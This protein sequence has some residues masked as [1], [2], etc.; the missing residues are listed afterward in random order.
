VY[1]DHAAVLDR[2]TGELDGVLDRHA[3]VEQT[4]AQA[5]REGV[6]HR[7]HP[8]AEHP[9]DE[10]AEEH[11]Q[12]HEWAAERARAQVDLAVRRLVDDQVRRSLRV[13]RV[14]AGQLLAQAPAVER[15][16]LDAASLGPAARLLGQVVGV[17]RHPAEVDG[18]VVAHELQHLGATLEEGVAPNLGGVVADDRVEVALGV[19]QL[20]GRVADLARLAQRVVAGDPDPAAGAG[21]R[22]TEVVALLDEERVQPE[23]RRPEG[24]RHARPSGADHDD[25]NDPLQRHACLHVPNGDPSSEKL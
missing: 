22:A 17:V 20:P 18:R 15:P 10:P 21:G 7:V 13:R 23:V 19:G 16:R 24:G 4:L 6:A 5:D 3:G 14:Q 12:H 8:A 11:P 2:E 1:A 9:G 25:I